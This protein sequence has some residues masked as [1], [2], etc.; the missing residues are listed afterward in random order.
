MVQDQSDLGDVQNTDVPTAALTLTRAQTQQQAALAVEAK[1]E[2][3]PNLFSM[4]G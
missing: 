3:Q 4:L 1:V 2:Q